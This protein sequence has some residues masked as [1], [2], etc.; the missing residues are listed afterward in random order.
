M[1]K[2]KTVSGKKVPVFEIWGMW[3]HTI[4]IITLV[5]TR[6]VGK[7]YRFENCK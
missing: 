1:L 5:K 2:Y 4:D 3:S 6:F 7:I